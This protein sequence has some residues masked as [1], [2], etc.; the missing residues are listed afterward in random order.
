MFN[1]LLDY[2]RL[3]N[4]NIVLIWGFSLI[5]LIDVWKVDEKGVMWYLKLENLCFRVGINI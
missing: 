5:F 4:Y 1:I 2:K 3:G